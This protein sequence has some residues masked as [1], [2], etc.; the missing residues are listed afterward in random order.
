MAV[1]RRPERRRPRP[2]RRSADLWLLLTPRQR[3]VLDLVAGGASNK[4]I[5]AQLNVSEQAIKQHVS[6]L[7]TRF[8]LETRTSLAQAA[9]AIRITGQRES[10]LPLEYLFD[11]APIAMA[12]TS[13]P[14]H[15][16]RA[17]NHTFIELFGDRDGW[18]GHRLT[19]LL[20]P[21]ESSL[22]PLV[23][24]VY[25]A[26]TG[27]R[28]VGVP[29]RWIGSDGPIERSLTIKV[30]PTRGPTGTVSGLVFF[31]IDVSEQIDLRVQLRTVQAERQ[32]I[33]EQLPSGISVA[34][35]DPAGRTLLLNGP[36]R[37]VMGDQLD[38]SQPLAA[39]IA[40]FGMRWA[41]TGLPL[42]A[43]DS[44]S[45]RALAG[46]SVSAHLIGRLGP[47]G[48]EYDGHVQG[49]PIRGVDGAIV[50][51]VLVFERLTRT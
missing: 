42:N 21:S 51:A 5:A 36:I 3:R 26:G 48:L 43:K 41:D 19:D 12:L 39:Q 20:E 30:E 18:I 45:V 35:V 6:R 38:Q 49:H 44:P 40:P 16:L 25:R 22:L 31:G 9:L 32:A 4:E 24:A 10:D 17:V 27:V 34:V 2:G 28:H 50:G 29:V 11:R 7:L 37:T 8:G 13:G 1:T 23:D 15:L 33:V 47:D 14:E 46:N